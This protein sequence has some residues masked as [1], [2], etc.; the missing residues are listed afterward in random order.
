MSNVIGILYRSG[1]LAPLG[2]RLTVLPTPR[3]PSPAFMTTLFLKPLLH[4]V[5]KYGFIHLAWCGCG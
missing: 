2:Y 4:L 5:F 3:D 1:R